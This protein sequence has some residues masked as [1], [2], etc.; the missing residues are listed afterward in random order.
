M[1][2]DG[3]WTRSGEQT[4]VGS[5]QPDF[6]AG[7]HTALTYKDFSLSL[8]FDS[9][10][11][12]QIVSGTYN[13]G[14]FTGVLKSSLYGRAAEYGGLERK[15]TDGRIVY[16][17]MIPEGVFDKDTKIKGVDV[18]GKT[19]QWAYEQKL[20]DP[21]SASAY[22]DSKY[23]WQYGI[24][25]EAV[26]DISWIALREISLRWNMPKKLAHK[27]YLQNVNLG[28][29]VR[30][31]GYLYNSLPDNIHP[32]GLSSNRS[33]EFIEVGGA[34]YARTYGFNVNITF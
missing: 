14:M 21:V 26:Q 33:Y 25:E 3:T 20:V 18:G 5:A 13:Y 24:R 9:R 30:N 32:E 17:G 2:P 23:S 12:G 16:D 34:A 10:F 1:N 8:L 31:V 28:L 29:L 19:Y 11:G 15:L 6:I 27:L 4:K 7:F 22:Y